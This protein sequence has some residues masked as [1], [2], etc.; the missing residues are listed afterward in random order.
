MYLFGRTT[1]LAPAHLLDGL[2]W[3]TTITEKVNQVTA[4]SVG[5]WTPVLSQGIGEISWSCF[6]ETLTDLENAEAKLLADPIYVDLVKQGAE[7]TIG[8]T[9]DLVAQILSPVPANYEP[10]THVTIVQ[11]QLANGNFQRGVAHGLEIAAQAT[12]LSGLTTSFLL[13]TTGAYGGCAWITGATSLQALEA[14]QN[15]A[16][17]DADFQKLIDSEPKVFVEG[18]TRTRIT[19]RIA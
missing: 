7:L 16:N 1:R 13:G 4:L 3:V 12:K 15:V 8:G 9:D 14:G 19:R 17:V 10:P 18:I 11:S 5:A 2:G 6:V